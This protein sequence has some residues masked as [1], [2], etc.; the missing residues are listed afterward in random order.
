MSTI[1]APQSALAGTRL[2]CERLGPL[3][4]VNEFLARLD[5]DARLARFVPSSG[6][7]KLPYAVALGVLLRSLL[8]ER[9]P[10]YRQA[11]V[12]ADFA[13]SAFG[14]SAAQA[15]SFTDDALGRALDQ[16]FDADRASFITDVIVAAGNE[17]GVKLTELHN[18]STSVKFTGQYRQAE[19]RSVR[20]Q[21]APFVTRGFSKDHPPDLKQLLFILTTSGD[22]G[23]PV[24]FR[25]QA[26]TRTTAARTFEPGTR[27][28]NSSATRTSCTSL[29]ASS[30]A[31]RQ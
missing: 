4:L 22:G 18:D 7:V 20:G 23:V 11:E 1:Q 14:L 6:R 21:Q 25:S 15:V 16:L 26:A 9:E 12:V 28:K 17:F 19:G 30:A 5:L 27:S 24:Q 29:I 10:V 13:P 8:V 3:P 31:A 2:V